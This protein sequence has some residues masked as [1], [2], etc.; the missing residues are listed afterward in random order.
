MIAADAAPT[1]E[2]VAAPTIGYVLGAFP[3]LSETFVSGE[4]RAMQTLGARVA[5]FVFDLRPGGDVAEAEDLVRRARRIA[6]LPDILPRGFCAA[7]LLGALAL[8]RHLPI[9]ARASAFRHALRLAAAAREAGCGWLHS[10]FAGGAALHALAAA[11]LIGIGASFT[12][13]S[14]AFARNFPSDRLI[15]PMVGAA[16]LCVAV[17][18]DL[19]Q[20][21]DA[22]GARRTALIPCGADLA[23]FARAPALAPNGRVLFVGRLIDCKGA[24]DLLRALS[25]LPEARR[26]GLDL[27]GDGPE[28]LALE[29]LARGLG[30]DARF[31][32]PRPN[33]WL[34]ERGSGYLGLAAPFRL[35]RD[36]QVDSAPV[37]LKEAMALGLPIVTT[38]LGGVVE[39]VGD[40][41]AAVAPGDVDGLARALA[42]LSGMTRAERAVRAAL[43]RSLAARFGRDA[44]AAA[45]LS[46]ILEARR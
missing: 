28:R 26:P 32:G 33:A 34:A 2:A 14:G 27:V 11:K 1:A 12:V 3:V 24:D 46:A 43:S 39:T 18:A 44:Q 21:L 38:R 35:G 23:R 37:V 13:H 9:R 7:G 10:H 6:D 16:D 25:R 40:A 19:E 15:A 41:A 17:S 20:A 42:A 5:P 4:M 31:L 22:A 30:L 36:G 45:L 29:A 8:L